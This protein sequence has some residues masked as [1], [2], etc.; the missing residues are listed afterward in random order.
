LLADRHLRNLI[1]PAVEGLA[2]SEALVITTT[3]GF[4]AER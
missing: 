2:G 1:L 3:V 4:D